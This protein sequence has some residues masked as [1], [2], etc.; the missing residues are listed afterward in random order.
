M[1]FEQFKLTDHV[2]I[3]TAA[4]RGIGAG[5]ATTFAEAGADIV[6]AARSAEQLA[7]TAAAVERF[8]RRCLVVQ[9]NLAEP[10]ALEDL[11][12]AAVAEF[13]RIDSVVNNLGGTFPAAF[14]DV[15]RAKFERAISF[16]VGTAY[17]LT[18]ASLPHLLESPNGSV[19]NIASVAGSM[20]GRAMS[21]YG[22]AK[23]AM[24]SLTRQL[25]QELAPK[26]RVNA[27]APGFIETQA[28]EL[29]TTSDEM[30]ETAISNTPMRRFGL[31]SDIGNAALYL[32][33]PA[34]SFVTGVLLPV[35][36]G[37]EGPVLDFGTPDL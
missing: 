36:G 2:A 9:A 26:V 29:V 18:Q 6:I 11:A 3:V 12:A 35:H 37:A 24:I 27:I 33:S 22:T 14:A 21:S 31:P 7:E 28:T 32:A 15:S 13:G 25:A 30:R 17:E 8:G 20:A 1:A 4:G 19:I 16:N 34:A 10:G 5:I 23:A